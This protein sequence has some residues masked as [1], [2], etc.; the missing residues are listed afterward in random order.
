M[1]LQR[2]LGANERFFHAIVAK[3][4]RDATI[5]RRYFDKAIVPAIGA[6]PARDVTAEDVRTIIWKKKKE[7]GFDAAAG[8]IRGLLK[9]L[10][11]YAQTIRPSPCSRNCRPWPAAVSWPCPGG[12]V[13]PSLSRT[14]PSTTH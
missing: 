1:V 11:D 2:L 14:T 7:G 6:K 9:R 12:A 5:P 4:R 13:W 10:F 3:D 8:S